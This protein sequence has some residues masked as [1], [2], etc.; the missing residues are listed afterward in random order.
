LNGKILVVDDSYAEMQM[1]ESVL[2]G[3]EYS[4]VAL[5]DAAHI[6]EI[7]VADKPDVI[8]LDI[9][10]PGRN[11]FQVCRDLKT[12]ERFVDIPIVLCTSKGQESDKFWGMQQGANAHVV[13]P[14]KAQDLLAAVKRVLESKGQRSPL[15]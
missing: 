13:K 8:V 7:I 12:D 15:S 6:E 3:A 14:F 4:V 5:P 1:M 11:G 10:M 9:V 2:K